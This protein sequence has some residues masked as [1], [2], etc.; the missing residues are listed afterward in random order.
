MITLTG[1]DK[2]ALLRSRGQLHVG[3]HQ[4]KGT[5]GKP[6]MPWRYCTNCGLL[7]LKN[8]VTRRA[9]RAPCTWEE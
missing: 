6:A 3:V 2:L 5:I 8:D 7:A 1:A 9:L 4:M